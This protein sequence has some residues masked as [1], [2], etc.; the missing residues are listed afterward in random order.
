MII[1]FLSSCNRDFVIHSFHQGTGVDDSYHERT[2]P[3]SYQHIDFAIVDACPALE[4]ENRMDSCFCFSSYWQ[5]EDMRT[6]TISS[7]VKPVKPWGVKMY[8]PP[9]DGFPP[10]LGRR[11]YDFV[12]FG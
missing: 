7:F 1:Y 12:N 9:R 8:E 3:A 6:G 2:Q 5:D 10:H 11:V 4:T